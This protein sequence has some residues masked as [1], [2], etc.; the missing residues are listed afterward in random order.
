MDK[1]ASLAQTSTIYSQVGDVDDQT[2]VSDLVTIMKAYNMDDS[3]AIDIVDRLDKLGNEYATDAKSL[4]EGLKNVASTMSLAGVDLDKTL[5]ILTGGAEITQNAGE[6]GNALK[7]SVL[8]LRGQ[9]GKLE[10]IGEYADD[11]ES[12]SQMQTK[13]IN[14]TKGAVNIMDSAD[15]TSF[16]DYY[17]V[18]KDISE[19]LPTMNENDQA[20]LIETLFGK[21]RANQGMAIIQAFQS[22]QIQKAYETSMNS[23]GTALEEHEKRM[24]SI[25]AKAEQLTASWQK[26][27]QTV[28]SSDFAKGTLD[29]GRG[30]LDFLNACISRVGTF[31]TILG[32]LAIYKGFSSGE[33]HR[34][35]KERHWSV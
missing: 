15:P 22:G 14:L 35:H 18:M 13:I 5:A 12:V 19:L 2:A 3:Q 32:G 29:F 20:N 10:D 6:L 31:K 4:G 9:K 16:R 34:F 28:I 25:S 26:L 30:I 24:D 7:V 17:D 21:N 33:P 11:V 27:S 1:S 8:R 23:E